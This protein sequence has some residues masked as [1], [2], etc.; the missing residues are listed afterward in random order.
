MAMSTKIASTTFAVIA[1]A[2]ALTFLALNSFFH[3]AIA[4]N[5]AGIL[6]ALTTGS[7]FDT[8]P[9]LTR[10]LTPI[11]L[12]PAL[13]FNINP[14]TTGSGVQDQFNLDQVDQYV[15]QK[16]LTSMENLV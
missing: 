11:S 15:K 8:Q 4:T 14:A 6:N 3:L 7:G 12:L 13:G 16:D 10:S 5:D 2:A 9:T 1:I